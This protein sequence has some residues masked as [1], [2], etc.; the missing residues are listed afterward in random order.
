MVKSDLLTILL[1]YFSVSCLLFGCLC[2]MHAVGQITNYW[3]DMQT[4]FWRHYDIDKNKKFLFDQQQAVLHIQALTRIVFFKLHQEASLQHGPELK[5]IYREYMAKIS[6]ISMHLFDQ[7]VDYAL[8]HPKMMEK[9]IRAYEDMWRQTFEKTPLVN[10]DDETLQHESI[11]AFWRDSGKKTAAMMVSGMLAL[12]PQLPMSGTW[13][14][15]P[16]ITQQEHKPAAPTPLDQQDRDLLI[17]EI[18]RALQ[19]LRHKKGREPNIDVHDDVF[20]ILEEKLTQFARLYAPQ[21][22]R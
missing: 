12:A 19:K 8:H 22:T 7:Q 4:I 13:E 9:M 2:M 21:K 18:L 5:N 11:A 6:E 17:R 10:G 20:Q 14:G 1:Y 15:Q 3:R 16:I